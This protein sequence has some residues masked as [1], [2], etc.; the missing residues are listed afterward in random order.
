MQK[1]SAEIS[2]FRNFIFGVEDSLVST[3]GLLSGVAI[4]G[5]P[6]ETIFLTGV[7]LIFV[8]AISMAAG[9][10]LSESSAEEFANRADKNGSKTCFAAF[11]MFVSYFISGFIPLAP[12][13]MFAPAV[14]L[15]V[16]IGIS[17]LALAILGA[18]TA[19]LSKVSLAKSA[20][21]MASIGGLAILVGTLVGHFVTTG[22]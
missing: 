14:A 8:E 4:A 20:L 19:R 16:S 12:Y 9:S 15:P 22:F 11:V 2:Y 21:R 5:M 3:V 7:V 13:L 6:V 10:F 17:I 1:S 18:V